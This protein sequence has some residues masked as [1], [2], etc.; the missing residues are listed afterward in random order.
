MKKDVMK[1]L[2]IVGIGF[3]IALIGYPFLHEMGHIFASLLV[4][5][6]V[7]ELTLFPVPSV[8]CDVTSVDTTGLVVIG[9]GG[10]IFPFLTS[11]IIPRKWFE[12]WCAR[13]I[14]Q[15]I[16]MLSLV[17]SCVSILFSV[18]HQDDMI[19]VLNFW[20]SGKTA[21]LV[22]LCASAVATLAAIAHD[23]PGRRICRFFGV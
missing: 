16:T 19:Q 2:L 1:L 7:L 21:L 10:V 23:R 5:A 11:L 12:T 15:G 18:N 4:G 20:E 13:A 3:F 9:F 17:I 14:L 6:K 22:I 8:L